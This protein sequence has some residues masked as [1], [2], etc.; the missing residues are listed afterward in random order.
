MQPIQQ[1]IQLDRSTNLALP[2]FEGKFGKVN[3]G[4][5]KLS[6][7]IDKVYMPWAK[8]NKKSW[9][10]DYYN[11]YT[12][13]EYFK[14]K[15]LRQIRPL[16]VEKFK[17]KRLATET[18]HDMPRA[19]ASVNREYEMPSRIFNLAIDVGKAD[20]NPCLRVKKFKLDNE[21]YRYLTPPEEDQL[22]KCLVREREHLYSMVVIALG[23]GLR[24]RE[25]LNLRRDQVDFSRNVVIAS[26][27]KGRR[28]REIPMDVLD[29]RIKDVL[30]ILCRNKK[31]D[32]F[33]FV[34]PRTGNPYTDIKR[35]FGTVC[36]KAKV[37]DLEW[38]DLRATFCTRLALAG[39][40][41]FTIKAIMG[42][43]D[44]KTTE[45]YI[46]ANRLTQQVHFLRVGHK[47]DTHEKRPPMLAA[48]SC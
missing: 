27:T 45:R 42:H 10:N 47:L 33:V 9:L 30:Q 24:K 16:D 4:T 22:I 11:S 29:S 25:Q 23:L 5:M 26:R 7:F 32:E 6:D 2:L 31:A 8:T 21:R 39:Y 48:V 37:N 18:K 3:A 13:K 35:A 20:S 34:N 40:D 15:E 41:A 1:C 44:M 17:S 36:L 28:N 12:I 19:P 14:G 43:K 46:R 38:H